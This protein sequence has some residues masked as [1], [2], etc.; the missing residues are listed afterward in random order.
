MIRTAIRFAILLALLA[1][2][3]PAPPARAANMTYYV[4]SSEGD[5]DNDGL[6]ELT[7]FETVG[8]VNSLDLGPGDRVL[9]KCGDTWH[10]EQLVIGDSGV[11]GNPITFGSYPEDCANKPIL[12]G[13]QPISGWTSSGTPNI[14]V[15][16]LSTGANANKFAY[17]IN[18]LFRGSERL[19]M[20]RWP[21]LDAGNGGYATIDSQPAGNRI[22]D[23]GLPAGDW[24]G[25]VAHIRGMTWYI[26]NREVTGDSG[27]TLTLNASA[28][29]WGGCT[30]WGYFLNDHLNTLDQEGEWYVD[31]EAHLVYLY[32]TGG[33]PA[34]EEVEGSVILKDANRSWGGVM[35]GVDL[36]E[37]GISYVVVENLDVRRWFR[38][39]IATPTNHAHYENHHVTL[40]NNAISDVDS[41]GIN[42]M[43]WVWGA[44]DG[45]PD[46]WR[47]GY[48]MTVEGNVVDTANRMG[49]NTASRNSTFSNNV[50]RD[51]GLI[52]NLGAAGLGCGFT[53]GEG[54]CTEDGDGFRI[55]IDE[56][57][58]TGNYNTVT[59]NRFE[60]IA[61]NG[62]DVFGHHNTFEH[63]VIYDACYT[64]ADCGSVRTFGRDG[65]SQTAV[66]DL[67]FQENIF[68]NAIGN[69]DGCKA[70]VGV[71][72]FGFYIDN[73]SRD[74][75]LTGNTVVSAT[76]HGILFQNSTGS[77]TG[78]TLYNNG[79]AWDYAAQ[80]YVGSSPAYVGTHTGNVLYSPRQAVRTLSVAG[81]SRIGTS[82]NNYF[83]NPY[84]AN[85]ISAS[86]DRTLSSWQSYSGK[87]G[88][89][90][91]HWFTLNPG[92]PPLSRIFYNDTKAPLVIDLGERKYLDRD[93]NQ[94]QG[95][96]TLQ[97]FESIVLI[98]DGF[99]ELTL[100]S[101]STTFWGADEPADFT[102]IL[103]GGM[104]TE[105]S[106]VRWDGSDRPSGFVN[107]SVLTATIYAADV[108]TVADVPVTVYDPGGD[109]TET[110]PL[111]FY[112][113]AH[114]YRIR[115]PLVL[116]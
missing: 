38:H 1:A 30:S 68:V 33:A 19:P 74:V 105:N 51:V 42:L 88:A 66:H 75:T 110:P 4:S 109:P 103:Y 31:T 49:I 37:P 28:G 48:N 60:R 86:G 46:G 58:D 94:V 13:A 52:E 114:V 106:V 97:P 56:A 14:Y 91:E 34:D 84:W 16:N 87:D 17:G 6:T 39:G 27:P 11:A 71:R 26:L 100:Q 3:A 96:I 59:G 78:N 22:T 24:T 104:F 99:A 65:L 53:D 50:I 7:P 77:V 69:M 80:V 90:V 43:S 112:V 57:N 5:D 98:D 29:C 73:Y 79:R 41:I 108:S 20:G 101:M 35:L 2:V 18:Q 107:S 8:K 83:F 63:N 23:N 81:L 36:N 113:V 82:N 70:G 115:L 116:R 64:K 93:Q 45:R 95:L 15:A 102:L 55:K 40:Q 111:T 67:T 76:V 12:S 21:N 54:A 85:H 44:Q 92:D 72:A 61:Y 9:F 89:S 32:T 10:A 47:G 25:A 62:M